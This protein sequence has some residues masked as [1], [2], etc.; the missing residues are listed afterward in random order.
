MNRGF[1]LIE[2][3]TTIAIIGILTAGL[4]MTL[5][6][7]G[8]AQKARDAKRKADFSQMQ[9]ALE[10][11]YN[12]NNKYPTSTASYQITGVAWGA[13]WGSY[14]QILPKDPQSPAKDYAYSAASDGTWYKLYARLEKGANDPQTCGSCG[15]G[16][17]YQYGVSSSNTSP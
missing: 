2:L 7:F 16:N 4:L 13:S 3:L 6:P 17:A 12:D 10:A 5:N 1:T 8:Q 14:M 11:Y 15:P 9:K